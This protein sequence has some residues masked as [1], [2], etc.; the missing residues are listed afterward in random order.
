MY[1]AFYPATC[2]NQWHDGD[3]RTANPFV[4]VY[5][6]VLRRRIYEYIN[7]QQT[8]KIDILPLYGQT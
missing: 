4:V 2:L 6:G 5:I 3:E 8:H 7:Y 1:P